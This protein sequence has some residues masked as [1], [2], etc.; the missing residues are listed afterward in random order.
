MVAPVL[1]GIQFAEFCGGYL[2]YGREV[3]FKLVVC[4]LGSK[5]PSV[6][7]CRT[8]SFRGSGGT[9]LYTHLINAMGH[10]FPIWFYV[11]ASCPQRVWTSW[12]LLIQSDTPTSQAADTSAP[13][14][15]SSFTWISLPSV[16][17]HS[18]F[19]HSA[20]MHLQACT[21]TFRYWNPRGWSSIYKRN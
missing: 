18:S 4:S 11:T 5:T 2:W 21:Q 20:N 3:I 16:Y 1:S 15:N 14:L 13:F 9:G 8:K 12:A 7:Y 17:P 10:H 19:V 6:N